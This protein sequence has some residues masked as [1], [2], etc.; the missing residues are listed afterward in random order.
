M[1]SV[2]AVMFLFLKT[3]MSVKITEV[4]IPSIMGISL[5]TSSG[6]KTDSKAGELSKVFMERVTSAAWLLLWYGTLKKDTL[7]FR[8]SQL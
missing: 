1:M 4:N 5:I 3:S 6:V 8:I 2:L 7:Y